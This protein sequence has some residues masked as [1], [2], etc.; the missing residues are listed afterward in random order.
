MSKDTE[1]QVASE[2][3]CRQPPLGFPSRTREIA[4]LDTSNA[5]RISSFEPLWHLQ[6]AAP[7]QWRET[8]KN[9]YPVSA[10]SSVMHEEREVSA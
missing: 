1:T 7:Q 6:F 9:Q 10:D 5:A 4:E 3:Q 8:L 2:Q